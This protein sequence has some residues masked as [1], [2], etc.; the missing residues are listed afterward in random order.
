MRCF[1]D[2]WFLEY[3]SCCHVSY[4]KLGLDVVFAF[5]SFP[6]PFPS[7]NEREENQVPCPK[8]MLNH[9]FAPKQKAKRVNHNTWIST[10]L[11]L[12]VGSCVVPLPFLTKFTSLLG[13][14]CQPLWNLTCV[15]L[16]AGESSKG[17][18]LW[19]GLQGS[20]CPWMRESHPFWLHHSLAF[21]PV[22]Y[23]ALTVLGSGDPG[24]NTRH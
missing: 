11:F 3:Q 22:N 16:I 17:D 8:D 19:S 13:R 18:L 10:S 24:W 6:L 23:I 7:V 15:S 9:Q 12:A 14:S 5:D 20:K 1:C 4:G 21:P 2:S